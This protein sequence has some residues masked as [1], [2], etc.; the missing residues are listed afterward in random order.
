VEHDHPLRLIIEVEQTH[1]LA[2]SIG[3]EHEGMRPFLGWVGLGSEL[4][5]LLT[6]ADETEMEDLDTS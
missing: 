6:E 3:G 1:P 4:D 5:R 2:G